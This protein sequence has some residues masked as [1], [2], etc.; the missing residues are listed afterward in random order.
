M[1]KEK[2]M[3]LSKLL[4]DVECGSFSEAA[5]AKH[6]I[7]SELHTLNLILQHLFL[8]CEEN[9][10]D[11]SPGSTGGPEEPRSI[12]ANG[13]CLDPE[14]V[15]GIILCCDKEK[16]SDVYSYLKRTE[17]SLLFTNRLEQAL[18]MQKE[19]INSGLTP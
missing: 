18:S 6:L 10:K 13:R 16:A 1:E 14:M 15:M 11:I 4:Y 5:K 19:H 17:H 2:E 12:A 9:K 8:V 3:T 7:V